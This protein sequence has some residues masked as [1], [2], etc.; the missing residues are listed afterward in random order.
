L[1]T[2]AKPMCRIV[3]VVGTQRVVADLEAIDGT[4][5]SI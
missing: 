1:A 4:R 3:R 5:S 2:P